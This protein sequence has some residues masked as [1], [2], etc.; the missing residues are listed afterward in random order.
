[1]GAAEFLLG[2]FLFVGLMWEIT[3]FLT[4]I[5]LWF[6]VLLV[7]KALVYNQQFACFCFGDGADI[8]SKLTLIR[9]ISLAI[10]S[11]LLIVMRTEYHPDTWYTN[12]VLQSI[13]ALSSMSV[14]SLLSSTKSLL[15]SNSYFTNKAK[16]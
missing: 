5:L 8:L 1:M 13:V 14:I 2:F 16:V 12:H 9:N 7:G 4:A 10:L 11:L 6:F 15:N 3:L